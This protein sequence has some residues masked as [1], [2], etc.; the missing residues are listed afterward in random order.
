M[1]FAKMFWILKKSI[2]VKIRMF[3][4]SASFLRLDL[5]IG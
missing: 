1:L 2:G 5:L 4:F 3:H